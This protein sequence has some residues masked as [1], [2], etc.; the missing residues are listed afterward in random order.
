MVK[1]GNVWKEKIIRPATQEEI[2]AY[3]VSKPDKDLVTMNCS[4]PDC[5]NLI[6]IPRNQK[7]TFNTTYLLRYGR[8]V[9]VY[10]CQE[11]QEAHL[12]MIGVSNGIKETANAQA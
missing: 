6:K 10:C 12:K 5:N 9:L 8:I 3:L 1:V 4:N 11:C 7:R 2:H